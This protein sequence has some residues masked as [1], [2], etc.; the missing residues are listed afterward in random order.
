MRKYLSS[1]DL[2]Y[3]RVVEWHQPD[4]FRHLEHLARTGTIAVQGA[5]LSIAPCSFGNSSSVINLSKFNRVLAFDPGASTLEVEAGITL[6]ELWEFLA[7]RG[8]WLPVQPGYAGISLGGCIATN[9]H[10]KNHYREGCFERW[11]ASLRLLHPDHGVVSAGRDEHADIFDLTCGGF[12]LTGIILSAVIRVVRLPGPRIA[13]RHVPVAD[14]AET[15]ATL[16]RLTADGDLAYTWNDLADFGSRIGRG[17]VVTGKIVA[18][19]AS[20]SNGRGGG[21]N[22][23]RRKLR[24]PLLNNVTLPLVN[25]AYYALTRSVTPRTV[26]CFDAL[27]PW[28]TAQIG[29]LYFDSFGRSGLLEPQVLIPLPRVPEYIAA[30][31]RLLRQYR[32]APALA[33]FKLFQG[34]QRL[35]RFDGTGLCCSFHFPNTGPTRRLLSDLDALNTELGGITNLCKDSRVTRKVA[36]AQ[37]PEFDEFVERLRR[38]DPKRRFSTELSERLGL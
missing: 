24:L 8:F 23:H 18:G 30:L 29:R 3:S 2:S 9:A 38:W 20:L 21:L 28:A 27:F 26:D 15:F 36:R 22:P 6:A 33:T 17:Y 12:G 34:A 13:V 37:Y 14:L 1:T 35:L 31:E 7:P 25:K 10:G 5:G 19:A 11:V 16:Q 4:R 32:Q